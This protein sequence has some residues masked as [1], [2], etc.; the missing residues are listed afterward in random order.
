MGFEP[1]LFLARY[2][3]AY[4][5]RDP[6]A[7]RSFFAL[8]DPRFGVFEDYAG[9]LFDGEAYGAILE[10]VFDAT[11]EMSFDLLRCDRFDDFAVVHAMQKVVEKDE[12]EGIGE[13]LIR[14]T[15]W[16]SIAGDQPRIVT[17]HF[18][19]CPASGA[20]CCLPGGCQGS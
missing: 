14:A 15:L 13:A 20:G 9:V 5:S 10:A 8:D 3:D 18:S 4:N 12:D 6:D 1:Q 17:A 19:I 11:A 16:V 2:A 7:L